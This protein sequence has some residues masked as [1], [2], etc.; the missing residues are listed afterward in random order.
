LRCGKL[1][2]GTE[3]AANLEL[4]RA[5]IFVAAAAPRIEEGIIVLDDLNA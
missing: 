5:A 4:D 2:A 3:T 1:L